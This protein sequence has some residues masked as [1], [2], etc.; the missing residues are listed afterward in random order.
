MPV[1]EWYHKYR[2]RIYILG[3]L[4]IDLFSRGTVEQVH[5]RTRQILEQCTPGGCFCM[6]TGNSVTNFCKTENSYAM[7]DETKM[8]DEEHGY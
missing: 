7:L 8:W 4:G 6:G 5:A 3:D 1:E 2:D